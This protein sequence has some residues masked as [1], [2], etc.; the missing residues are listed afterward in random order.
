MVSFRVTIQI[1]LKWYR[2]LQDCYRLELLLVTKIGVKRDL[3]I[4]L[5]NNLTYPSRLFFQFKN[6]FSLNLHQSNTELTVAKP[7]VINDIM[8][9]IPRLTLPYF[10]SA[11]NYDLIQYLY[12]R[13][14]ELEEEK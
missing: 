8:P 10:L 13:I 14:D 7:T 3:Q 11:K 6:K 4:P 1:R 2:G 9:P 5:T 12:S